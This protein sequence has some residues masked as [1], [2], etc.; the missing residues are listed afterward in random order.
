MI[1]L[2][3][4]DLSNILGH[5]QR[6]IASGRQSIRHHRHLVLEQFCHA[7]NLPTPTYST[8]QNGK[9]ISA[10]IANLHF[11]HSHTNDHYA[12][13]YSL[14][15]SNIGVDIERIDRN[16]AFDKLAK[17]YFHPDEYTAWQNGG[18]QRRTW[19]TIWT[20]KEAVLKAH[21]IGIR[22][23]LSQ[24]NTHFASPHHGIAHHPTL[25][26]FKVRVMDTNH[27]IISIAHPSHY[28]PVIVA[29]NSF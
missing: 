9:P 22:T 18:Y 17:R 25:G 29:N 15:I 5:K 20:A 10:N 6:L 12:L 3:H 2:Y 4:T 11:N 23:R 28:R 27:H 14:N 19:F 16:P 7:Q 1:Y 24:L 26:S 13:I 8:D 21:G